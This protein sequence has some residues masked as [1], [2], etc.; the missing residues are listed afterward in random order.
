MA[1]R[2][3][4][5]VNVISARSFGTSTVVVSLVSVL[6]AYVELVSHDSVTGKHE[7]HVPRPYVSKIVV[8]W[9]CLLSHGIIRGSL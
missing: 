3:S 9:K 1:S 8:N 6:K 5:C 2:K 7:R 4:E